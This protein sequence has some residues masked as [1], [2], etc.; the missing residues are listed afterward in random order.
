MNASKSPAK[1]IRAPA[2]ARLY[3]FFNGEGWMR[4]GPFQLIQFD[5]SGKIIDENGDVLAI[6]VG[7]E[8]EA[9]EKLG[10]GLINLRNPII[11]SRP[12]LPPKI[13][14]R[15]WGLRDIAESEFFTQ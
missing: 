6:Q 3:L 14:N 13:R 1:E 4:F 7:Q 5:E 8:W 12:N 15:G 11:F 9:T 10:R 2:S